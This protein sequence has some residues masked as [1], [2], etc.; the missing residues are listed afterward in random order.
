MARPRRGRLGPLETSGATS[1]RHD[2]QHVGNGLVQRV[3]DD[4][5]VRQGD[6]HWLFFFGLAEPF[7]DFAL[8]VAAHREPLALLFA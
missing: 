2:G 4:H 7:V 6:A 3:V 1:L 5:V 8:I